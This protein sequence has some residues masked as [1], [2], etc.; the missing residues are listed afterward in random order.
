MFSPLTDEEREEIREG[1]IEY[2]KGETIT[3]KDS[4]TNELIE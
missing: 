4:C 2:K 1:T 3:W